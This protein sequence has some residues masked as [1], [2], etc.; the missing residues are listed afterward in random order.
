M[1]HLFPAAEIVVVGGK[2]LAELFGGDSRLLL[3][4]LSYRR[5]AT[6]IE[7]LLT[8]LD[9]LACVRE[10]TREAKP[11]ECLILDPDTRL[12]QLG[13]LPVTGS[14]ETPAEYLFFPSRE[15]GGGKSLS[16]GELT[17]EWLD[18]VFGEGARTYPRVSL[19]NEDI[20]IA[21]RLVGKVKGSGGRPVVTI[22]FGVGENPLKRVGEAFEVTILMRLIQEGVCIVLDKGAGEDEMARANA[23]V[24][25]LSGERSVRAVEITEQNL[26]EAMNSE[27]DSDILT[28][29]GRIGTLA[30]LIGESDLYIGYDSAGAHIAAALGVPCTDV[31]AG[32]GWNRFVERWRPSGKGPTRVVA[33][34]SRGDDN[35]ANIA[36][37]VLKHARE[38]LT[39]N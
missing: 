27:L 38:F 36:E 20:E 10:L 22:N 3:K 23:L 2:K 6:T 4:E 8:W 7:R 16:L 11:G 18:E 15:Y 19:R 5:T 1:K 29:N 30:A 37:T 24:A 12:T 31:F 13:L 28:W 33:I 21:R 34:E 14:D 9:L 32:Y 39:E 25:Q 26:V 17:S 35:E